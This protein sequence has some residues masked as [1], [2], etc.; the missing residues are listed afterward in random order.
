MKMRE[1]VVLFR[2]YLILLICKRIVDL[3]L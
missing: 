3:L 1:N 2:A